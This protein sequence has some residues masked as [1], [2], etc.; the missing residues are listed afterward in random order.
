MRLLLTHPYHLALDPR[1]DAL[2][3]P[4]PP[5][6]SLQAAAVAQQAGAEVVFY[7]PMFAADESSFAEVLAAHDVDAVAIIADDH[8]VQIKQ[9][10]LIHI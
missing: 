2:S 5:V 8:S 7:D 10:S 3:K 4:Y 6:G 9:L 1:E